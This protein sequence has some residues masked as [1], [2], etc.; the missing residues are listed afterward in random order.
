MFG[1]FVY[2]CDVFNRADDLH[3]DV[4]RQIAGCNRFHYHFAFLVIWE[5]SVVLPL[6]WWESC[7]CCRDSRF[8]IDVEQLFV[9][10]YESLIDDVVPEVIF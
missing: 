2:C 6:N 4:W 7:A 1:L 8:Q 10:L 9:L 5:A 3:T